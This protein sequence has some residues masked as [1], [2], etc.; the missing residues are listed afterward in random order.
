MIHEGSTVQIHPSQS[1]EIKRLLRT[2]LVSHAAFPF[3]DPSLGLLPMFS[4]DA[5]W[6]GVVN[7]GCIVGR[8]Y[9]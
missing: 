8:E 6:V 1:L 7:H 2:A 5:G 4:I 9:S 3:I